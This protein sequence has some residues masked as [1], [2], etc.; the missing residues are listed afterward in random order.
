MANGIIWARQRREE[1]EAEVDR[2]AGGREVGW[3]EGAGA[4][5]QEGGSE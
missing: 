2:Q 3:E 5:S 4:V 1:A